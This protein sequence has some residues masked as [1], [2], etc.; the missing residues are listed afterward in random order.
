MSAPLV[1]LALFA[2]SLVLPVAYTAPLPSGWVTTH[3]QLE[4][5]THDGTFVIDVGDDCGDIAPGQ[6]VELF[7][8]SGDVGSINLIGSDHLCQIGFVASVSTDTCVTNG[9]GVCDVNVQGGT[10]G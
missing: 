4:L 3:P 9:D 5:V 2:Q 6:N 10:H 8:G 7:I 1:A